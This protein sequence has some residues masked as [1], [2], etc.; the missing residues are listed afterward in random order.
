MARPSLR[1]VVRPIWSP[2]GAYGH[3]RPPELIC[4][5]VT[6]SL[7]QDAAVPLPIAHSR[8][9]IDTLGHPYR[10]SDCANRAGASAAERLVPN[11]TLAA[12]HLHHNA[13][14]LRPKKSLKKKKTVKEPRQGSRVNARHQCA[15][16]GEGRWVWEKSGLR[17]RPR[18]MELP[19]R[20]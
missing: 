9:E 1:Q 14:S 4:G 16:A 13:L 6:R 11:A 5:G 7:L 2:S 15:F 17:A 12:L 3:G 19:P 8:I 18:L 20:F 10:M